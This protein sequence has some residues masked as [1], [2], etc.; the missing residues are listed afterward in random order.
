MDAQIGHGPER[1]AG[2]APDH[3]WLAEQVGVGRAVTDLAGEG[4]RM[5]ARALGGQVSEQSR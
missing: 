2:A 5:P 3:Q 1:P 4:D